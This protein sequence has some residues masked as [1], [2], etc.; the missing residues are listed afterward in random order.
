MMRPRP[1]PAQQHPQTVWARQALAHACLLAC[2]AGPALL[3]ATAAQAQ[4]NGANM[5]TGQVQTAAQAQTQAAAAALAQTPG[6]LRIT[7]VFDATVNVVNTSLDQ[8]QGQTLNRNG[9]VVTDLRPGV[10]LTGRLGRSRMSLY[11]ALD[12]R[13]HSR[14]LPGQAQADE[15][16]N[17]LN[18]SLSS[19]LIERWLSV[20]ASAAVSQQTISAYGQQSLDGSTFNTN[21]SE[22]AQ[23]SVRPYS[24]G[25]IADFATYDLTFS[26]DAIHVKRAATPGS[27]GTGI[28]LALSSANTGSLLGWGAQLTQQ[29][30]N[31]S[32]GQATD[33]TRATASLK[34]KPD[35]DVQAAVRVGQE[36]TKIS[37]VYDATYTNYGGEIRWTPS[38]RTSAS[39]SADQRYFGRA[40]QAALDH[41]MQRTSLRFSSSRDVSSSA[42]STG[43]GQPVTL[44]Q[45]FYSQ[46]AS[47]QPDP[48]LREQ[49]VRDFLASIGQDPNAV[50]SGGFV[51]AGVTLQR[52]DDVAFSYAAQRATFA[53]QAYRSSVSRLDTPGAVTVGSAPVHQ[54]GLSSSAIYRLTPE[55]TG[56]LSYSRLATQSTPTLGGNR[57]NS[58]TLNLSERLGHLTTVGI[59]A[60]YSVFDGPINPYH[61]TSLGGTLSLRF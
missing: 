21:R 15:L 32:G 3:A 57:L 1:V 43:V 23:L 40:Y 36:A 25:S 33:S 34:I 35:V 2:T 8:T 27:Q 6:G 28:S 49:M 22:V 48:V 11:Y 20:D 12:I 51:N 14:P 50:V 54:Y 29:H 30:S 60:R 37:G 47:L 18:A 53:L 31:F 61:E 17:A 59:T 13:R 19:Q 56:T 4:V 41:R 52:R 45:L 44:Y 58:L 5:D 46:F 16:K 39:I 42:G 55:R 24:R 26:A 38:S 7:P 9:D 10:Q